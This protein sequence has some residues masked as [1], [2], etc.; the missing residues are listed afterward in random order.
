MLH[1]LTTQILPP[2]DGEREPAVYEQAEKG[3]A[4]TAAGGWALL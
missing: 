2:T 1:G 4:H 3:L